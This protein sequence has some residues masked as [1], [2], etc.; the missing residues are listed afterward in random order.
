MRYRVPADVDM[1]DRIFAGLTVR[2]L[3]ILGADGLLLW[4]LFF[5]IG[6]RIGPAAFG[7]LAAPVAAA[8]LVV[9]TARPEGMWIE[10]LLVHAL[11]FWAAPRRRVL[12]PEGI[13]PRPRWLPRAER[14]A[15]VETPVA[16]VERSGIVDLGEEGT[17]LLARATSLN[18]GLRSEQE[19]AALVEGFGRMLNSLDAP[20]QFVVRAEPANLDSLVEGI[21]H[22][23][24][25][26]PHPDL[27]R[28][29]REHAA[30]LRSLSGRRDV[31][32]RSLLLCFRDPRTSAE[33]A[34]NLARRIDEAQTLLRGIGI[35]LDRLE[36]HEAVDAIARACGAPRMDGARQL[37]PGEVL[38]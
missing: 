38:R 37:L 27:E 25:T 33:A 2:Q 1:A 23:A 14:L 36:A 5:A 15:P 26:L 16:A 24:P 17:V 31:L 20:V 18:F 29:A 7:A 30:F 35:R 28:A 34:P 10:Q 19:Q 32:R 3:L 13:P 4:M 11:R 9:A 22:E 12:A 21:E 6:E 8:G